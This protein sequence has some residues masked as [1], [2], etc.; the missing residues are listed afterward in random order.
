MELRPPA[1]TG[2]LGPF[3]AG[4]W[5]FFLLNPLLEGWAR[6]DEVR[7]VVGMV[8]TIAFAAV[9]MACGSGSAPTGSG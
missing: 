3:F 8:S 4:I 9:Y 5:L 7:G 6:R 2:R 1:P